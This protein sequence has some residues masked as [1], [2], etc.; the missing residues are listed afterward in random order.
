MHDSACRTDILLPDHSRQYE[1]ISTRNDAAAPAEGVLLYMIG[2]MSALS[3][4][5][6]RRSG[7]F[8]LTT[9]PATTAELCQKSAIF[10]LVRAYLL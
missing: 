1:C 8:M 4:S 7:V 2:D 9:L 10:T 3:M 6:L 5:G